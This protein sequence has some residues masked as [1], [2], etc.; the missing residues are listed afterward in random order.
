MGLISPATSKTQ[1]FTKTIELLRKLKIFGMNVNKNAKE[2]LSLGFWV[3]KNKSDT[4][5]PNSWYNQT[6]PP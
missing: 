5:F 3:T 6:P 1:N 2:K 4:T